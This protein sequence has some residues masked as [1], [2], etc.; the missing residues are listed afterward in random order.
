MPDEI[1][2]DV[3]PVAEAVAD[4]PPPVAET[5]EDPEANPVDETQRRLA[6]RRD[7]LREEIEAAHRLPAGLKASLAERI[8]AIGFNDAGAEEPSLTLA[9]AVRLWEAA[10]PTGVAVAVQETRES[11]HPRGDGYFRGDP[12]SLTDED[13]ERIA[14]EQVRRSGFA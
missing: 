3:I 12:N 1:E 8:D 11:A 10:I 4:E 6:A 13:A 2:T 5:I 7:A 14:R 9:D